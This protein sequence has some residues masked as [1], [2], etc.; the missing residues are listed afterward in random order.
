MRRTRAQRGFKIFGVGVTALCVWICYA[1]AADLD[2]DALRQ[3]LVEFRDELLGFR[4]ESLQNGVELD[5]VEPAHPPLYR[6][7]ELLRSSEPRR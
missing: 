2:L 4:A 6:G 3:T 7:N 1:P 5:H